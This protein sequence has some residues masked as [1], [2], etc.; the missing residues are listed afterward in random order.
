MSPPSSA[1]AASHAQDAGAAPPIIDPADSRWLLIIL[2]MLLSFASISTDI[3]LPAMPAIAASLHAPNGM[4]QLT[5]SAFLV[6]FS[7][8]Q[9]IWGP[10]GDRHGRR[11]PIV[12]GLVLFMV[13]SAGCALSGSIEQMLAWRVVQALGACAGPVLARAMV[14]D[15][16]GREHA[17]RMMST[18]YLIMGVA[19]LVGPLVGGQILVLWSWRGIF[20]MLVLMG[21]AAMFLLRRLPESLP[22]ERRVKE[23]LYTSF[24]D[25]AMLAR[26]RKLIG[27]ALSGGFFYGA[28]YA[29]LAGTPFAYIEY[30]GVAPQVYGLL[31]GINIIGMMSANYLN[32]RLVMTQGSERMLRLGSWVVACA[33]IVLT[34][35]AGT[36]W[37]GLIGLIVPIF[38]FLAM[39][40]FIVANSV[41]GALSAFPHRAG[42]A[43]SL[44][45]AMHYGAGIL[46]AALVGWCADGTPWPMGWIMGVGGIGCLL[47][48][49][50]PTYLA[51]PLR[52][53]GR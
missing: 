51:R 17:A 36:G 45:G 11:M 12:A 3:Y 47:T 18:L 10:I 35:D 39:N 22:P 49:L 32:S 1:R 7:L 26:D 29:F 21:F 16:Y 46:S 20:W 34:I 37:G 4:V 42:S 31:F 41:A 15:L 53:P 28:I 2:S 50:A 25:Y 23:P 5:L 6:G 52:R 13:G 43:S 40:G 44:V 27:Y 38:F 48:T 19:P 24:K 30:Y 14:R 33:G 9:F 8:G